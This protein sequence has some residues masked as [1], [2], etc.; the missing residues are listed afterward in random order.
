MPLGRPLVPLTLTDEQQD[1]LNGIARS[2]TLPHALVPARAGLLV[3]LAEP[4]VR[5]GLQREALRSH[6]VER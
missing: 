6:T 5:E 2:A 1:Q 4:D 3:V